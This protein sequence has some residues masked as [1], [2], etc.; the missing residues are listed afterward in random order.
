M[1]SLWHSIPCLTPHWSSSRTIRGSFQK[2]IYILVHGASG[3]VG[4][5][6]LQFARSLPNAVVIGTAGTEEGRNAILQNGATH[7]LNHREENYLNSISEFTEGH[8]VDIILEMLANVNIAKDTKILALGG[9]IC[10]IGS[11]GSLDFTP[12]DLM[13][14][15]SELR[16]VFLNLMTNEEKKE[17][18]EGI[19]KGLQDGSVVP[20][21]EK[22]FKL[23][24]APEAHTLIMDS[25]RT[26]AG[27]IIIQPWEE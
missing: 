17:A 15:R 13:Q 12:R 5:A 21:I 23:S 19:N 16:G 24:E 4:T 18:V 6:A 14:K 1:D 25:S 22:T 11:R 7:C 2:N 9:R 8:G 10:V 26:S 3:G 20:I 27:K